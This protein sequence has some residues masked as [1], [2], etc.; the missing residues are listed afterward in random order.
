M[1]SIASKV[2]AVKSKHPFAQAFSEKRI[3]E[4]SAAEQRGPIPPKKIERV[5]ASRIADREEQKRVLFERVSADSCLE[6][7]GPRDRGRDSYLCAKCRAPFPR[8]ENFQEPINGWQFQIVAR[9]YDY[10]G[11]FTVQ[12]TDAFPPERKNRTE[13]IALCGSREEAEEKARKAL[14]RSMAAAW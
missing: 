12:K 7:G 11:E 1:R 5:L 9:G 3:R 8:V 4:M 6:C 2:S 10:M 14:R 13:F